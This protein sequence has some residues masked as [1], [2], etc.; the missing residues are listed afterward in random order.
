MEHSNLNLLKRLGGKCSKEA[1]CT[2]L[3]GQR[4]SMFKC[5]SDPPDAGHLGGMIKLK[6]APPSINYF[7][8][9]QT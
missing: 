3:A 7:E 8:Y 1:F 4:V 2:S 6:P 9:T 5:G